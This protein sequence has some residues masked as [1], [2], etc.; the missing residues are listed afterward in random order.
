MNRCL[1]CRTRKSPGARSGKA[2]KTRRRESPPTDRSL[3]RHESSL[4]RVRKTISA[5]IYSFQSV[6]AVPTFVRKEFSRHGGCNSIGLGVAA[7]EGACE[8]VRSEVQSDWRPVASVSEDR[9]EGSGAWLKADEPRSG[10]GRRRHLPRTPPGPDCRHRK[11]RYFAAAYTSARHRRAAVT[12]S[13]GWT[14]FAPVTRPGSTAD[15][16]LDAPASVQAY[17]LVFCQSHRPDCVR[18]RRCAGCCRRR[19]F[20]PPARRELLTTRPLS[21]QRPLAPR[22]RDAD[23][24]LAQRLTASR[25]EAPERFTLASASPPGPAPAASG[26]SGLKLTF[27]LGKSAAVASSQPS[28]AVSHTPPVPQPHYARP[29]PPPAAAPAPAPAGLAYSP[30]PRYTP[31]QAAPGHAPPYSPGQAA[32]AAAY[33]RE[34]D[35]GDD[36]DDHDSGDR[37]SAVKYRKLKKLYFAAIEASPALLVLFSCRSD[38]VSP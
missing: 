31:H 38:L 36:D 23:C 15:S 1:D 19:E 34:Q 35:S 18:V 20:S 4:Q 33:A 13:G 26:S 32:Y 8:S 21:S 12:R 9:V 30:G 25:A 37:V 11:C 5:V 27:K 7:K 28:V 2:P 22:G 10:R 16:G 17:L 6:R 14:F 29:T 24:T 3:G